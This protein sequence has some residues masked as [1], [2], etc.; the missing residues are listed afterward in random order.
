MIFFLRHTLGLWLLYRG[1]MW[2]KVHAIALKA[3]GGWRLILAYLY[4]A[5]VYPA[6]AL[7]N[8]IYGTALQLGIGTLLFSDTLARI[9]QNPRAFFIWQRR[10]ADYFCEK[11]LN[12]YDPRGHHC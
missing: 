12:P 4:L 3:R 6:D 5:F 7:Y 11:L 10:L 1:A 9:R 2:L 8:L